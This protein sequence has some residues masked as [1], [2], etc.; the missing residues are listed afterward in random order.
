MTVT[1]SFSR[2]SRVSLDKDRIRMRQDHH[3]VM[4]LALNPTNHAKRL[5]KIHPPMPRCV[6]QRHEDLFGAAFLLPDIIGDK[7]ALC[8]FL[9]LLNRSLGR[10]QSKTIVHQF[11]DNFFR[12]IIQFKRF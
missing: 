9:Q 3:E 2:L 10:N 8:L 7:H 12:A 11:F 4:Q 1:E 5:A 6:A